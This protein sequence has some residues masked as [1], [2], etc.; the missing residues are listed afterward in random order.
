LYDY[1]C[2]NAAQTQISRVNGEDGGSASTKI[3]Y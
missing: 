3:V 1:K 2:G